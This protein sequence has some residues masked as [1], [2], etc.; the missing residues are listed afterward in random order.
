MQL[1]NYQNNIIIPNSKLYFTNLLCNYY[2]TLYQKYLHIFINLIKHNN[3]KNNSFY[4]NSFYNKL[5]I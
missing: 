4:L 3:F 1:N 2:I 5:Y